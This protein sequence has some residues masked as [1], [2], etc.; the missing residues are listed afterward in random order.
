MS[1][2]NWENLDVCGTLEP[3]YSV[4]AFCKI[5]KIVCVVFSKHFSLCHFCSKIAYS[6]FVYAIFSPC[7]FMDEELR[8]CRSA[9][10]LS[11]DNVGTGCCTTEADIARWIHIFLPAINLVLTKTR[12]VFSGD[13]ATTLKVKI[14]LLPIFA[15]FQY[16][17]FKTV[18]LVCSP[19][20][21]NSQV[22]VFLFVVGRK[23]LHFLLL[24]LGNCYSPNCQ[25]QTC[26]MQN[27]EVTNLELV[28]LC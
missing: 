12:Q 11:E 5:A 9:A 13:P 20:L 16:Q 19:S 21:S 23:I 25:K 8:G 27:M 22:L 14:C 1:N 10:Q 15:I 18:I 26:K 17:Y 4:T 7:Y 24:A 3:W 2:T 6:L 28:G